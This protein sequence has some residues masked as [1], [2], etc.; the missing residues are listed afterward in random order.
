MAYP[1]VLV[2]ED[3]PVVLTMTCDELKA[4]GL[5]V[6]KAPT[7]DA[8][9]AILAS[10]GPE[11]AVVVSDIKTPGERDGMSFAEE[12]RASWPD[13][14]LVLT[15]G[16][17]T[18]AAEALAADMHFIEKPY[19]YKEMAELVVSL[20][21]PDG[22]DD[23]RTFASAPDLQAGGW[24]DRRLGRRLRRRRLDKGL[25]QFELAKRIGV[26]LDRLQSYERGE[27]RM[28]AS[29]LIDAAIALELSPGDLLK[30]VAK[31]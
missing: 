8:G 22:A 26:T 17:V 28:S 3:D 31:D 14:R 25:R 20:L 4:A 7:V 1:L 13:L 5:D 15:S 6:V 27:V 29:V 9:I 30:G 12:I 21:T 11:L 16:K 10:L 2:V 23:H 19:D 18:V 24:I